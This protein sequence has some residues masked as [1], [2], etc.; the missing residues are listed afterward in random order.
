MAG[1][2][3]SWSAALSAVMKVELS[4]AWSVAE[5]AYRSAVLSAAWMAAKRAVGL[6]E[7]SADR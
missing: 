2:M 7:Y 3:V 6:V 1:K 4:A 5:M